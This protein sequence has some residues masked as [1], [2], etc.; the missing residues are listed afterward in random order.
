MKNNKQTDDH[1]KLLKG[2][3]IKGMATMIPLPF[4]LKRNTEKKL[5][6]K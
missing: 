1:L 3:I 6:V 2:L 4:F 5:S